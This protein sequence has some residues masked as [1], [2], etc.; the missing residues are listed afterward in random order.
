M[1]SEPAGSPRS[2][3]RWWMAI[4]VAIVAF[5][6]AFGIT[7]LVSGD[8]SSSTEPEPPQGISFTQAHGVP[9]GTSLPDFERRITVLPVQVVHRH[10]H[11]PQTC[12][13]YRL[14][15]VPSRYVFCFARGKLVV[16]YTG[17]NI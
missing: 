13:Y 5:G 14:T 8:G 12:R 1:E 11:P 17:P 3:V 15:D 9:L 6:I 7:R 4:P 10:T 16:A 2:R